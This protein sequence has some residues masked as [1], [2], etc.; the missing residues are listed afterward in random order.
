MD[1]PTLERMHTELLAISNR[2][3]LLEARATGEGPFVEGE[4]PTIADW[5]NH[6]VYGGS[7]GIVVDE[8]EA[9]ETPCVC[10]ELHGEHER[11][12]CFSRG[13]VGALDDEQKALFCPTTERR[14]PTPEQ[15]ARIEAFEAAAS[16]CKPLEEQQPHGEQRLEVW[17]SCMA[18]ELKSRQPPQA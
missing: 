16:A 14:E 13:V 6:G 2:V 5:V 15:R 3:S 17:L 12:L 1:E 9:R 10:Y 8:V 4:R 18:R 11:E 7:P